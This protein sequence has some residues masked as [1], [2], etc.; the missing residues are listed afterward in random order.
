M[1]RRVLVLLGCAALLAPSACSNDL[2]TAPKLSRLE[3][4]SAIREDPDIVLT[5]HKHTV[6]LRGSRL[7][8]DG[9]Q[10]GEVNA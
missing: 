9:I 1:I 3:D 5:G 10:H 6:V 4:S 8:I 7:F 2:A